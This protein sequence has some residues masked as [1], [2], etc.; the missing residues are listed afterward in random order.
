MKKLTVNAADMELDRVLEFIKQELTKVNCDEFN[1]LQ[2]FIAVEEIFVN[3]AHYAY[4]E[5]T[6]KATIQCEIKENPRRI[7]ITFMDRGVPYNPL[8]REEP[9][10][11]LTAENRG[12]GGLGIFMVKKSM[13]KVEYRYENGRNILTISK[14]LNQGTN[15]D[16]QR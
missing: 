8:L 16:S 15:P 7:E 4:P 9:D 11:R 5:G 3:I 10:I 1:N 14:G 2:L 12:I 6:G 13:D